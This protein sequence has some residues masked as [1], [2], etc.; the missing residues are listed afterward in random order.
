MKRIVPIFLPLAL[1]LAAAPLS[2]KESQP[3]QYKTIVVKHFINSNGTSQSQDFINYFCDSLVVQL[4]KIKIAGQVVDEGVTVPAA[5]AAASIVIE[6]KFTEFGKG[7]LFAPGSLGVEID[8]YRVSDRAL[9]K[10]TTAK[11]PF[12][13]S[14]ANKDKNVAEFTGGQTAYLV[15]Q[16]LKGVNLSSIP[17]AP[18]GANPA[19]PGSTTP[20]TSAQSSPEA[21]ASVQFSSDPTG[22][23]IA[24]DGDY[25]GSTPSL[26]KMKPGTHSVKIAKN[27]YQPWVRSIEIAGGES[28][29]LAAELEPVKP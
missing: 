20:S 28:R 4:E 29:N 7:G 21:T 10:T 18:P 8:I 11:V 16:A 25:A 22:A 17:P 26:I 1:L 24:I 27:G 15:R 19:S 12:K 2:A 13:S 23:E 14:P 3:P 9:V 6:G 5:D